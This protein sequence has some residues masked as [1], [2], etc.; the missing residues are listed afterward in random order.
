MRKVLLLL[1]T[2]LF[3]AGLASAK[4][5]TIE[6][7]NAASENNLDTSS[8]MMEQV[9][10]GAGYIDEFA[11]ML[12]IKSGKEGIRIDKGLNFTIN[13]STQGQVAATSVVV[14][15]R[16]RAGMMGFSAGTLTLNDK[17]SE[18]VSDATSD[19]DLTFDLDGSK[20]TNISLKANANF[21]IKSI[22]VTYAPT[23]S[24]VFANAASENNLDTS[25]AMMEQVTD[26]TGYIEEFVDMLNIKSGKEGIRI[27][28]GLNFTINL[29]TQG[30]VA[31]TSVVVKVRGRAG[32]M[33]F[34]AGTL[35]LNDKESETV[36]DATSD[37]D[38]T[39]DLDGSKLTNISLKANA[40]FYIKSITVKEGGVKKDIELAF[41]A[42]TASAVVG[43][44]FTAPKLTCSVDGLEITYS[45]SNP[46]V[47]TV[48]ADGK[49]TPVSV[50][51]T[52]ITASF[53]GNNEYRNAH[54]SYTLTV[55]GVISSWKNFTDLDAV[56]P[57]KSL[58][59][60][61]NFPT[62]V[63]YQGI[64]TTNTGVSAKHT[65]VV[66]NDV[67]MLVYGDETPD[68]EVGDV[69]PT[70]WTATYK[71]PNSAKYYCAVVVDAPKSASEKET[72]TPAVVENV[73]GLKR[74]GVYMVKDVTFENG[75]TPT[76]TGDIYGTYTEI[77]GRDETEN[78][79]IKFRQYFGLDNLAA[80]KYNV[81]FVVEDNGAGSQI[82]C[83]VKYELVQ[84][85]GVESIEEDETP[86]EYF[87]LE[88]IRV[89][90]P[91][92]GIYIR[93]QGE[94]VTKFLIK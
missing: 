7:K 45:S 63:T 8:A 30:Q 20:L 82:L 66:A 21:Y 12:N 52:R 15:V 92:K 42:E 22:T 2:V 5:Y 64:G 60:K 79:E 34:S 19:K 23:Y 41:D 61:I 13:L 89:E 48:A 56:Q 47:A 65:Y 53:A 91:A 10:D 4:S 24:I 28:K 18:T 31:A 71:S 26:G 86:A 83:P 87:T 69:I 93:R 77:D 57:F 70:G 90:K 85:S 62:T 43:E 32:M 50:G 33:G 44:E 74:Y 39:F 67:P 49:V 58:T 11:D 14:K 73:K 76:V 25:S 29:S 37:K 27:D 55:M 9:T 40:N 51:E 68:Y 94:K 59:A 38:L 3:S 78:K 80:G 75:T 84:G 46:A 6:F 16:G 36:S 35:T 81:T 72:F 1:L 88:G 17:E 54:T